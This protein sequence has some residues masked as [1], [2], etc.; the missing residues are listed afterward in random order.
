MNAHSVRRAAAPKFAALV[1]A[2]LALAAASCGGMHGSTQTKGAP[3]PQVAHA[4]IEGRSGSHVAGQA[5]FISTNDGV[6][7][8]V[9]VTG[10][11]PGAH[12][13]HLHDKGDCSSADAMSAGPHF[14]PSQHAHGSPQADPHHAG[15]FGNMQVGPD[16]SGTLELVS[17]DLTVDP[18]LNCVVGHSIVVHGGTD[19]FTTQPAGNAGPR[20]G[21]GVVVAGP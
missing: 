18:G 1:P 9:H 6:R 8:E 15:D 13:V 14:N 12:A 10:A 2:A 3:G 4:V 20:I 19:D 17:R 16:S 5:S 7:I 21:C 11:S